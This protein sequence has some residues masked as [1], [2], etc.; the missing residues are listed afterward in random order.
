MLISVGIL[1]HNEADKIGD[2]IS[3]I[4]NQ[5]LLSNEKISIEIHVI[6]N[7]CTDATIGVSSEA[8][9]AQPFQRQNITTYIHKI[10]R[11][12][13][14][15]AWNE[16]VHTFASP[17]TEFA[18]FLDADIRIPE[19]TTLQLILDTII[20]AKTAR[21]AVDESVKDLSS[22]SHKTIIER[23]IL[24]A[25]Q[26]AYD[27][28]TAICGQL[29]CVRFKVLQKIWM[30]IGLPGEDGFLR[31]MI[32]TS[33]FTENEN[34]DHIIF[35]GRARHIFESESSLRGVFRHNIRLAIG[36]AINV[37]LFKHVRELS[38]IQRDVGKYI[39]GRN[40]TDPNWINE[41]IDNERHQGKYFL[42]H[43]GFLSKRLERVS[44]LSFSERLQKAP[45]IAVGLIFD[46]ALFFAANSLMRR[47]AG[48]GYW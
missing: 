17:K 24:A 46:L 5:T 18:F 36:T 6:A 3:D 10:D 9:V 7:G 27:T 12:G 28:R 42:L 2:L 21:V 38:S 35:V 1:A 32:L 16:F 43:R 13:K 30:P 8:F 15:N 11:A 34:F 33:N 22:K 25:S 45:I 20:Q 41:L 40:A 31:A 44:S 47:G 23:L 14:S 39:K 19:T 4:G 48:A 37:L 26:T 29:Y